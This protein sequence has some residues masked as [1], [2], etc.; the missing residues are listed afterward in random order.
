MNSRFPRLAIVPR[1]L[2]IVEELGGMAPVAAALR[3][4]A[5]N[6]VATLWGEDGP[7]EV[8]IITGEIPATEQHSDSTPGSLR[9]YGADVHVTAGT[10]LPELLGRW[11]I[12]DGANRLFG[13]TVEATCYA[14]IADA[15]HDGHT[16]LLVLVDG[17]FGLADNS[18]VGEID[19]AAD[20]DALCLSL[21]GQ[22]SA[23]VDFQDV[24]FPAPGEYAAALWQEL[25]KVATYWEK[26]ERVDV[27]KYVHYSDAPY[28]IGYHV[29]SWRCVGK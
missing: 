1:A 11:L 21:A 28:G 3:S 4:A 17:A 10:T 9:P 26:S 20:T 14:H 2:L 19:G 27:V 13:H 23:A 25:D 15:L 16:R 5:R 12:E 24:T 22:S 7:G 6:A 8:A 29:A 18:P